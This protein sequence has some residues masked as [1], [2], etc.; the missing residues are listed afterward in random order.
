MGS[1]IGINL[2]PVDDQLLCV[3]DTPICSC[4]I[5]PGKDCLFLTQRNFM[6]LGYSA[7]GISSAASA[8]RWN[9]LLLIVPAAHRLKLSENEFWILLLRRPSWEDHDD[10][11]ALKERVAQ[12]VTA[13][14]LMDILMSQAPMNSKWY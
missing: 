12:A 8:S 14:E 3:V 10:F 1:R 4:S 7:A 9:T 11:N 5:L 2:R 13:K 6:A